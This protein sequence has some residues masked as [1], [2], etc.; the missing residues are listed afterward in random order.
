MSWKL[1]YCHDRL[2]NGKA[3]FEYARGIVVSEKTENITIADISNKRIQVQYCYY[4][5][6]G[7]FIQP[8]STLLH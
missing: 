7:N 3:E 5:N 6:F 4:E 1:T 2:G 8:F